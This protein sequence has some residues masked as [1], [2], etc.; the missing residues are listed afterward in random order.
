MPT[1]KRISVPGAIVHIM[2]RGINGM[3]IFTDD[4]DRCYYLELFT[5]SIEATGYLCYA[6]VLM[7]THSHFVVRCSEKP[8]SELMR[9]LNSQYAK[10]FNKK[11]NRHGY[12]FQDRFKSIITQDQKYLESLIRYV[13][14]NPLRARVCETLK[15]LDTYPWC[16]HSVLLGNSF[17]P[18]QTTKSVLHR[19]G[20]DIN[21]GIKKYQEYM[22]EGSLAEKN[23]DGIIESIR[24]SNKGIEKKNEKPC[25]VI[26]DRDFVLSVM[27]KNEKRLH[28]S[29]ALREA[30]PLENVLSKLA[31]IAGVKPE[32]IKEVSRLSKSSECKKKFA[33]I[34]CRILGFPV[35]EVAKCIGVTGPS[36]S[37]LIKEGKKI[38]KKSEIN[39]FTILPPG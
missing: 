2:V 8:L 27:K 38:V 26:G 6:W 23:G 36:V 20:T 10:Y 5:K 11:N 33:F 4:S 17:Q 31:D 30:W 34:S 28:R 24:R 39:K 22:A 3:E 1:K 12:V 29:I 14:L 32:L 16:G 13:H 35:S 19:F 7:S 15:V 21:S 9:M 25:W 18:F 37:W